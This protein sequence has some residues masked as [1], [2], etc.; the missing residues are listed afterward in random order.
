MKKTRVHIKTEH[1]G[2]KHGG[3]GFYGHHQDAKEE[4]KVARRQHDK[5]EISEQ[6]DVTDPG[7][8][9]LG[10][11]VGYEAGEIDGRNKGAAIA[12]GII[13]MGYALRSKYFEEWIKELSQ[14]TVSRMKEQK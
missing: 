13:G 4:C 12:F 10:F 7:D 3:S 5:V 14:I 6:L 1:A 2:A 8:Y 9:D 11:D